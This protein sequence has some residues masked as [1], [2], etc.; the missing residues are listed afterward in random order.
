MT[1]SVETQVGPY[2][3]VALLGAGGM[4]EVWCAGD[5]QL[6]HDGDLPPSTVLLLLVRE[7]RNP[8]AKDDQRQ[9]QMEGHGV[10]YDLRV[11]S[12]TINYP[13]R[14]GLV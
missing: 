5:P 14:C 12:L 6:G 7:P 13:L 2:Q 11:A 4:G 3:I 1:L 9:E 8:E 10:G